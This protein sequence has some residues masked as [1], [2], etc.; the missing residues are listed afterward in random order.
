MA[1]ELVT[2]KKGTVHV[3]SADD[4]A[5]YAA[6]AGKGEYVLDLDDRLA[7]TMTTA[8]KAHVASGHGLMQ[9]RHWLIDAEGVDLTIQNGTQGQK[10]NDLIVARYECDA[11]NGNIESVA[12][13]VIKGTPTTGTPAD[14]AC[15][16]GDILEGAALVNEQPLWRIPLNGITVGTPIQMFDVL[17]PAKE[18]WDSVAP[19][20][21]AT[22]PPARG[23]YAEASVPDISRYQWLYV[24]GL[25]E[26]L[27]T[28]LVP[29]PVFRAAPGRRFHSTLPAGNA[30]GYEANIEYVSDTKIK[31][32]VGTYITSMDI[33]GIGRA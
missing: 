18:A 9:G 32:R 4:G 21:L 10:R 1:I 5:L 33:Y 8:N 23:T 12:L 30:T 27:P 3:D 6:I 14:P 26:E 20:L 16:R 11:K 2:G 13:K 28:L 7:C 19:V 24:L 25:G 31:Y 15:T 17:T 22:L 29:V